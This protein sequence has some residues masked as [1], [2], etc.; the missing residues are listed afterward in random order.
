MPP[1][2]ALCSSCRSSAP[3]RASSFT[4][5]PAAP[6]RTFTPARS[7][8][9]TDTST[10]TCSTSSP[11]SRSNRIPI[12]IIHTLTRA[13]TRTIAG[14]ARCR[15]STI[16][17]PRARDTGIPRTPCS[18][19]HFCSRR[20]LSPVCS[21]GLPAMPVRAASTSS[22][23][24]RTT[25]AAL[26]SRTALPEAGRTRPLDQ[27]ARGVAPARVRHE[28]RRRAASSARYTCGRAELR[29]LA[30]PYPSTGGAPR[31][32]GCCRRQGCPDV[33]GAWLPGSPGYK[34]A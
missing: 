12:R 9:P 3:V 16:T 10:T 26:Q 33:G 15:S 24:D 18:V 21:S 7:R 23:T 1:Q 27:R 14:R 4:I 29:Q 6:A 19:R 5:T 30:D 2:R 13:R 22:R 34:R 32:L 28:G 8:Q 11:T 25:P 17:F 20:R 31:R